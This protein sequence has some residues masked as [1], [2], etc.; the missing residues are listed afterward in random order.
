MAMTK[1]QIEKKTVENTFTKEEMEFFKSANLEIADVQ[2]ESE[3]FEPLA[4]G[5]HL[6]LT[7]EINS[8][9]GQSGH[10][11]VYVVKEQAE[12]WIE[13]RKRRTHDVAK[14]F[15]LWAFLVDGRKEPIDNMRAWDIVEV[16][17][18]NPSY[19]D[20]LAYKKGE[21]SPID[22]LDTLL[23]QRL[24]ELYEDESF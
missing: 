22:E 13:F 5:D 24:V 3:W 2:L 10:F 17:Q 14:D 23:R 6:V 18:M 4:E 12:A 11:K 15:V 7:R 16:S 8:L 9:F 19:E 1:K 21:N 20:I